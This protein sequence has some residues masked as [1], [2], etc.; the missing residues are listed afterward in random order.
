MQ[1]T[2]WNWKILDEFIDHQKYER[3]APLNTILSYRRDLTEFLDYLGKERHGLKD[4]DHNIMRK[5]LSELHKKKNSKSTSSRKTSNIRTFFKFCLKKGWVDNNP[6]TEIFLPKFNRP[7]PS[8]LT[9]LETVELLCQ[10]IIAIRDKTILELLYATGMRVGE[11]SKVNTFNIDYEQRTIR[12]MGKGR[13]ERFVFYGREAAKSLKYYLL[14]R[15]LFAKE[16]SEE[17][18]LF[19]NSRGARLTE[20][21][22]QKMVK[23]YCQA[24]GLKKEITPHSLR[25]SFA[26]HLLS[27]GAD[28]RYIQ[29]FLGHA[30]LATTERYLHVDIQQLK[31]AYFRSHPTASGGIHSR[32]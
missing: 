2:S 25:H 32:D 21:S 30:S 28:I 26:S 12:V 13:K 8:F 1:G 19:L 11:L 10:P 22:I 5:F 16:K 20:R 9:I 6:A 15:P 17:T 29:E 7:L 18:A 23:K 3:N 4:V 31:K 24:L 27:R 14:V